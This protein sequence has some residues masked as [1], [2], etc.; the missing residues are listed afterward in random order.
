MP[1]PDCDI[2]IAGASY[3]GLSLALALDHLLEGQAAITVAARASDLAISADSPRAF[4]ISHASK[5]LLNVIGIWPQVASESEPVTTIELTDSPLSAGVRPVL[6]TYDNLLEHG[7]AASHIVPSGM[8]G[9]ALLKQV[10][11]RPAI[12]IV[13]ASISGFERIGETVSVTCETGAAP[14]AA[15]LACA[16]GQSAP[17]LR[18]AGIA[19]VGWG[20][21]QTGIVA[22]IAH[23]RPHGGKA[24]QHFLPNGPF[25]ILPLPGNRCC[26]TW[27]ED[28]READRILALDDEDFLD[29]VDLRFGGKLGPLRLDGPRQGFPL[30]TRLARRYIAARFALVGDAAHRVHPIAGQGLNLALRDVAA[31]S[32]CIADGV[33]VGLDFGDHTLLERYERWR[34]FDSTLSAGA[35][36]II[37]RFF[38]VDWPL[39]RAVRETGMS[40]LDRLPGIKALLVS[41]AAG[42]TGEVPSLLRAE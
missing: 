24:V 15:L 8:L 6:M 23:E 38:R 19:T 35:F 30:A 36:D 14:T 18:S 25:A 10:K 40:M 27:S 37:N 29:E 20:H 4:A 34:R 31:L 26:I 2:L 33:R 1:K 5:N 22:T 7:E 17:L 39:A 28:A 12:T 3:S 32:E 42:R 16:T 41:E 21:G 9:G 11:D 13:E